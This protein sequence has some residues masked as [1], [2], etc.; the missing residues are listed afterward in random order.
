MFPGR[1]VSR[2]IMGAEPGGAEEDAS[3]RYFS[4]SSGAGDAGATGGAIP[5]AWRARIISALRSTDV[6]DADA[7]NFYYQQQQQ[8]QG[9]QDREPCSAQCAQLPPLNMAEDSHSAPRGEYHRQHGD[10]VL[11]GEERCGAALQMHHA[12]Q[13]QQQQQQ[14]QQ[15]HGS[16]RSSTSSSC[17]ADEVGGMD[18]VALLLAS[19][20]QRD[21]QPSRRVQAAPPQGLA[22]RH[23]H[24]HEQ[25]AEHA[26][27]AHYRNDLQQQQQ[28]QQSQ[29]QQQPRRSSFELQHDLQMSGQ[30]SVACDVCDSMTLGCDASSAGNN[31]GNSANGGGNR[32]GSERSGPASLRRQGGGGGGSSASA[33]AGGGNI[34]SGGGGGRGGGGGGGCGGI[35][36]V[37]GLRR[38]LPSNNDDDGEAVDGYANDEFRMFE[39][40]VRRC[41]RG[42]SHDWTE[43][44]FAHPGEKARRRDPRR[45][46]YSGTACPDFRKGTCRRGDACEYAHGVFECWLHPSRYRTQPCKDGRNCKRRVCFFAHTPA[47]LRLMPSAA[48]AAAA[49]AAAG[50]DGSTGDASA[51]FGGGSGVTGGVGAA[52]GG[53]SGCNNNEQPITGTALVVDD[54][55]PTSVFPCDLAAPTRGCGPDRA[56]ATAAAAAAASAAAASA[57]AAAA[58]AAAAEAAAAAAEA[59]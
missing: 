10:A 46:H 44:P 5:S 25:V 53:K 16:R 8:Q 33:G 18:A 20:P 17:A 40:K 29:Q 55:S 6:L 3:Q 2:M 37:G 26:L 57:A 14:E 12:L 23:P 52:D 48:A 31:V 15:Q 50:G 11:P 34:T 41:M 38:F 28:Q 22:P 27:A 24:D 4:R 13:Q 59:G 30:R 39:F 9:Q 56:C 49:A 42:R 58:A 19:L 54:S 7:L 35:P 36:D 45:Y 32:G 43:C 21:C 1:L 47:Q 51:A